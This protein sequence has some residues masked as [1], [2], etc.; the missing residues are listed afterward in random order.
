MKQYYAVKV[1]NLETGRYVELWKQVNPTR[2]SVQ[3]Q[4]KK[5]GKDWKKWDFCRM[6]FIPC[7]NPT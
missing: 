1:L 3:Y 4:L 5:E 6:V 2:Q 7:A